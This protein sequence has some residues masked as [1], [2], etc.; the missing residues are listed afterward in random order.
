[1][2]HIDVIKILLDIPQTQIY[3]LVEFGH[4]DTLSGLRQVQRFTSNFNVN[5]Y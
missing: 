2:H 3:A 4:H 5:A 1:M